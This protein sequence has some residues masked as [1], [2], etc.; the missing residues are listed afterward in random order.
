[1][2]TKRQRADDL[3]TIP[4]IGPSM[5]LDLRDLGVQRVK[6]L[7]GKDPEEMYKALCDL[8]G[9]HIDRCV[10]YVFRCA[11]Y[12]AGNQTHDPELLKWWNWKERESAT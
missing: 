5:S 12:F 11:I 6:D 2:T 10:L 4:G 8:R 7:V 9:S 1:M 3:E